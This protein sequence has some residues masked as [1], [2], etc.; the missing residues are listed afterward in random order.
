MAGL[1]DGPLAAAFATGALPGRQSQIAHERSGVLETSQVAECGDEGDGHGE[2]H[3]THGLEGLDDRGETPALA[4]LSEVRLT[5][6]ESFIMF[7]HCPDILLEDELRGGGRT[8][9]CRPPA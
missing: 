9:D 7:R 5:A 3:A 4:L 1:G 2:L 8:D 6:L